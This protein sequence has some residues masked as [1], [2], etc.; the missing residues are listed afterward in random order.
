ME[1]CGILWI[2]VYPLSLIARKGEDMFFKF[3]LYDGIENFQVYAP[4]GGTILTKSPWDT[5]KDD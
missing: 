3:Y 4:F 2:T 1:F 5:H